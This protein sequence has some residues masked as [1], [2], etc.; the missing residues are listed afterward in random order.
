MHKASRSRCGFW[1]LVG[2]S[3][4]GAGCGSL[5]AQTVLSA[6]DAGEKPGA[7]P[8]EMVWANRLEPAPPTVRFDRLEGWAVRV[9]GGARA[10]LQLSQ[11]QNLWD[12]PVAR[13]RYAGN[14]QPDSGPRVILLPPQP[15]P[16]A[17]G[18]NALDAWIY[19]NRPSPSWPTCAM[20]PGDCT[21]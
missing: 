12:R 2:L 4:A 1:V 11:A 10:T 9:E 7:R 20:R 13:L 16:I 15:I 8:Y 14:G 5:A 21:A 3:C 18:A 6:L 17:A 19:G